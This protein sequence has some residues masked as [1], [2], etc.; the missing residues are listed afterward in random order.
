MIRCAILAVALTATVH[1]VE[2]QQ[3]WQATEIARIEG[4]RD[5]SAGLAADGSQRRAV[6]IATPTGTIELTF[7]GGGIR[8]RGPAVAAYGLLGPIPDSRAGHGTRSIGAAFLVGPTRR[9]RHGVLGDDVEAEAVVAYPLGMPVPLGDI[10]RAPLRYTLPADSVFEDLVP[11]VADLDGDG[12]DEIVVVR[13]YLDRGAAVAVLGVRGNRLA[14]LAESP[15]LGRPNRWLDPAGI[16]DFLG[17]GRNRRQIAVV[18]TPHIG[19]VLVIYEYTA[20]R[21]V[22]RVRR[23]GY[24]THVI[25]STVI[26]MAAIADLDGDGADDILLPTQDRTA[27]VALRLRGG[28]PVEFARIAV[29]APV[30]T[31][32]LALDLDGGG[33]PGVVFG[34]ADG[35]VFWLRR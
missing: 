12:Q 1:A 19:G 20:G 23:H 24:S 34:A 31:S 26:G 11:R 30:A 22:E 7:A 29:P 17:L 25:G 21:L 14:L 18:E 27:I 5:I 8:Q 3:P 16:G 2:A 28:A 32:I 4:L 13:S 6:W 9:Y 33:R 35:R 10:T 15:P